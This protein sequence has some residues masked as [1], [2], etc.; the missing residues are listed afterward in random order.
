MTPAALLFD[1]DN[2]LV[3]SWEVIHTALAETFTAM[4]ERPWSL[5][6][7]K[8]KVRA[9]ARDAF[10]RLFGDRGAE[11]SR[12]FYDAFRRS[13]IEKLEALAGAEAPA[14]APERERA[15]SRHRV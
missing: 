11:A 6:E 5:Q 10:P 4:G 12:I 2:T 9:S 13:H 7:C 14:A 1:W 3:D 8:E 15:T